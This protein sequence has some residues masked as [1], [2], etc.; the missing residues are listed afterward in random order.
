[1]KHSRLFMK[2]RA[3]AFSII[4]LISFAWIVLLCVFLALRWAQSNGTQRSFV[5]GF[6]ILDVVTVIM[7]PVLLI[8]EFRPYLDAARMTF[9]LMSHFGVASAFLFVYK[10]I[11]CNDHTIDGPGVCQLL[12]IYI[13]MSS[14]VI[15]ALLLI[16]FIC[17]A[18]YSHRNKYRLPTSSTSETSSFSDA[19]SGKPSWKRATLPI[20]DLEPAPVYVPRRRS[21]PPSP[22]PV[23]SITIP[24]PGL[25]DVDRP[26]PTVSRSAVDERSPFAPRPASSRQTSSSSFANKPLPIPNHAALGVVKHVVPK[27]PMTP[28]TRRRTLPARSPLVLHDG[29]REKAYDER[30]AS[31]PRRGSMPES[32][33]HRPALQHQQI[34]PA[35][36]RRQFGTYPTA[37]GQSPARKHLSV[38][39]TSRRR[40]VSPTSTQES[41][42][43]PRLDA[44]WGWAVPFTRGAGS[45]PGSSSGAAS[46]RHVSLASALTPRS[47]E[48]EGKARLVK[49]PVNEVL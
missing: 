44:T 31:R 9:L 33:P 10:T 30:R 49:Q 2:G 32:S 36:G 46:S 22:R 7:L 8:C 17:L 16:Y 28:S 21:K 48:E 20:M 13:I 18:W 14:W 1:M 4:T 5:V 15:P 41:M 6:L 3:I 45:G 34:P 38:P 29:D 39:P 37:G 23:L 24:P 35:S 12:N 40:S 11:T 25:P 47:S 43:V 26:L 27:Q 42:T 19:E